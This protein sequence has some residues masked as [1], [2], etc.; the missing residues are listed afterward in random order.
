MRD[1]LGRW[2]IQREII[3]DRANSRGR[4]EGYANFQMLDGWELPTMLYEERGE[5]SLGSTGPIQ[6][7]RRYL[8][9]LHDNDSVHVLFE[10]GRPFHEINLSQTMPYATHFCD[11]DVYDVSYDLRDWPAWTCAWRVR[12]PRKDYRMETR[13]RLVGDLT[14]LRGACAQPSGQA[15]SAATKLKP[16]G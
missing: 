1:F 15:D 11:P 6:A 5:L 12:G 13:Y 3:D 10:D 4:L 7:E 16:K 14:W 9:Q 8:W 2:T